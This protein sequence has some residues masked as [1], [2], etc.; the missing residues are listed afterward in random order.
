M[1]DPAVTAEAH[2]KHRSAHYLQ[3]EG[4]PSSTDPYRLEVLMSV[5]LPSR[6]SKTH[7]AD[8]QLAHR[9][10]RHLAAESRAVSR[11]QIQVDDGVV[12]LRGVATSFYQKQLWL[13]GTKR[14]VGENGSINDQISVTPYWEDT[15]VGW[16]E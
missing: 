1:L 2:Q 4:L 3:T 15:D 14:V 10:Q 9:I 8:E 12:T 7:V 16:R 6:H 13:H 11:L 5:V